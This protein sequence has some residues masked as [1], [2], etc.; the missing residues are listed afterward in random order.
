MEVKSYRFQYDVA[1]RTHKRHREKNFSH[2]EKGYY[3]KQKQ[4]DRRRYNFLEGKS[5]GRIRRIKHNKSA[6]SFE[7]HA[8]AQVFEK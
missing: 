4:F 6:K 5:N 7:S 1:Q 8:N 2:N 3:K